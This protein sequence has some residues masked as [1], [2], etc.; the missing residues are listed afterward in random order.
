MCGFSNRDSFVNSSEKGI[1]EY[2]PEV[3]IWQNKDFHVEGLDCYVGLIFM[4]ISIN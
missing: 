3:G 1:L 4:L 2:L